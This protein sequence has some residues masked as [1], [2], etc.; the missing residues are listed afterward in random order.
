MRSSPARW[1]ALNARSA[2]L[3]AGIIAACKGLLDVQSP[4]RVPARNLEDPARA[5]LLVQSAI[6]DFECA[7]ANYVTATGVL[8]DELWASTPFT[9]NN[10]DLRTVGSGANYGTTD[11]A[12]YADGVLPAYFYGVYTPLSIARYQADFAFRLIDAFD[13]SLVPGGDTTKARLM[14]TA[15]AYAGYS[16]TVFGEGMCQ[17]AFDRGPA[18]DSRDVLGIALQK[19]TTALSIAQADSSVVYM[20]RVGRARVRTDLAVKADSVG[21][22]AL[23]ALLRADA[24]A[25][26]RLVPPAFVRYANRATRGPP[27]GKRRLRAQLGNRAHFRRSSIPQPQCGWRPRSTSPGKRCRTS[28]K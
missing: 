2:V 11:C 27:P 1:L 13:D 16:Y 22:V 25:E 19:F 12:K 7:L 3:M 9:P 23:A 20:A 26:A 14:A 4:T 6:A 18:L 28:R 21:D 24:A 8:T 17:A 5:A 10:W 15:A